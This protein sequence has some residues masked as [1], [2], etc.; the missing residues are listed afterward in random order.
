MFNLIKKHWNLLPRIAE[1]TSE[2]LSKSK[3]RGCGQLLALELEGE[4]P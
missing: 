1:V 4:M 3:G 2:S